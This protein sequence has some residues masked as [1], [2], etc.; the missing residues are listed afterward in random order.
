MK[1][2]PLTEEQ[3]PKPKLKIEFLRDILDGTT[4]QKNFN[5]DRV[6]IGI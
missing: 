1:N 6:E 3:E 2:L 4:C 5:A